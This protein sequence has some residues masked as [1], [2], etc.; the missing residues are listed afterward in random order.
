M[1]DFMFKSLNNTA[2]IA[3]TNNAMIIAFDNPFL[4]KVTNVNKNRVL[5]AI[6]KGTVS[7]A[8]AAKLAPEVTATNRS[9]TRTVLGSRA[10]TPPTLEPSRSA[11]Q[12][13]RE[14][15]VPAMTKESAAFTKMFP[16]C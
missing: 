5:I 13:D 14:I 11:P 4:A 12:V 16:I 8:S 6:P 10:N 15:H 1:T 9:E 2:I 7:A 3:H